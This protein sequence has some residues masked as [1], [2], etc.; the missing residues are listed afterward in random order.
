MQIVQIIAIFSAFAGLVSANSMDGVDNCQNKCD[1][2]FART[3][4]SISDQPNT[5]TF[6]NRACLIGCNLCTTELAAN[7]KLEDSKCFQNCKTFNYKNEGIRKGVIEPDK[8]CLMGCVINTCQQVCIG[9][10]TD[11]KVTEENQQWWWRQTVNGTGCAIKTESY[12]QNALY[13]NVNS[14]G[15]QGA[16]SAQR[17]CCTEAFNLCDYKGDTASVNYQN[18]LLVSKKACKAFVTP[19]SKPGICAYYNDPKNCGTP[20]MVPI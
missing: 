20:G 12:V 16:S 11:D 6:E 7:T 4:Y 14:P 19:F 1:K 10:T 17:Q 18:V 9:G 5:T 3:Q 8:A 2:V 15:G 13:G